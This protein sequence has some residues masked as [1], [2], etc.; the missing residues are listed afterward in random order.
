MFA[1]G[2]FLLAVKKVPASED[3]G[4]NIKTLV[5]SEVVCLQRC[6]ESGVI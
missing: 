3:T 4:Y 6:P 1:G 2:D 5:Q